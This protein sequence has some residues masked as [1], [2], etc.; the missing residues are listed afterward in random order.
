[1]YEAIYINTHLQE[2]LFS[3][4]V[5]AVAIKEQYFSRTC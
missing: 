4:I 5:G 1:M 3:R 2:I